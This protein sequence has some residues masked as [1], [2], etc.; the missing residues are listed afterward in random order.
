[1]SALVAGPAPTLRWSLHHFYNT[2]F[3]YHFISISLN[4][5][6]E[7]VATSTHLRSQHSDVA[8]STKSRFLSTPWPKAIIILTRRMVVHARR[9]HTPRLFCP[10]RAAEAELR[11]GMAVQVADLDTHEAFWVRVIRAGPE[12]VGR[13]HNLLVATTTYNIGDLIFVSAANTVRSN[14]DVDES[15]C[16]GDIDDTSNS[17]ADKLRIFSAVRHQPQ[18][19]HN[20]LGSHPC[21]EAFLGK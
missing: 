18:M 20:A 12:C 15:D 17:T 2:S 7:V 9:V 5:V 3:L 14:P 10:A 16:W 19:W 13:V 6:R 8:E 21:L 4:V 1:M 11:P